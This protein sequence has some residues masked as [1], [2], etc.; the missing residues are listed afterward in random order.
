MPRPIGGFDGRIRCIEMG[1]PQ[2]D[3][4]DWLAIADD[5]DEEDGG[6]TEGGA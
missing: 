1:K 3:G 2:P 4:P 5:A 6:E